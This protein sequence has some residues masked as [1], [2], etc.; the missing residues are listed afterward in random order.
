MGRK[1]EAA[2]PFVGPEARDLELYVICKSCGFPLATG[3]RMT[4]AELRATRL[5]DR[6]HRCPRCGHAA[7]Y[8]AE[9]YAHRA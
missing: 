1:R 3:I 9:D 7:V 2:P 5:E 6:E 8:R 4:P